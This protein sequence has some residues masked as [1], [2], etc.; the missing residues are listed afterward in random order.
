MASLV[1]LATCCSMVPALH[2]AAPARA[3]LT[4]LSAIR[5]TR[6]AAEQQKK[7]LFELA[8]WEEQKTLR[9]LDLSGFVQ[10]FDRGGVVLAGVFANQDGLAAIGRREPWRC[11]GIVAAEDEASLAL[12]VSR[13]RPLIEA[14]AYELVRDIRTEK[15][16]LRR[17]PFAP[18]IRLAWSPP[19]SFMLKVMDP[20][21]RGLAVF[22]E[23]PAATPVTSVRCGFLGTQSR[24]V[25]RE[26]GGTYFVNVELP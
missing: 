12:A 2:R 3:G 8:P 15:R 19:P 16:L 25:Q 26:T 1:M 5:A 22:N 20:K 7:A 10:P 23:V 11:I 24:D 6:Q 13:Q 14:W 4:E 21:S 17:G 9:R 18:P